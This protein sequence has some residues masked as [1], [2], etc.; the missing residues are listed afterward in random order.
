VT[1]AVGARDA[2]ASARKNGGG[3]NGLDLGKFDQFGQNLGQ[4]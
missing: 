4:N 1:N 2:A 3:Q